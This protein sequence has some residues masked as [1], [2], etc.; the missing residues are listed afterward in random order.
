MNQIKNRFTGTVICEGEETIEKKLASKKRADLYGAD[1]SGA[2][3]SGADLSG[4]DLSGANLSGADLSGADLSGADL[5]GADLSGAGPLR[6]KIEFW[7]F[8]S[9]RLLS[10]MN[11]GHLSCDLTTELFRRNVWAHPAPN[12]EELFRNGR[13]VVDVHQKEEQLLVFRSPKGVLEAGCAD[14]EG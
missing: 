13:M 1:L 14:H 10:S 5:S 12:A 8:P 3:L 6:F 2:D 4:A 7:Q 11:L 9:I